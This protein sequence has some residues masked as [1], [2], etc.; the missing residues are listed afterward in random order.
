MD[1]L[2]KRIVLKCHGGTLSIL[3]NVALRTLESDFVDIRYDKQQDTMILIVEKYECC[4][5]LGYSAV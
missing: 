2:H 3:S 5:L 1:L 4:H